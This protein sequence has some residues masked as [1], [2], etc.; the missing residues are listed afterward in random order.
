M[1][2]INDNWDFL[3]T[4]K[5]IYVSIL[6][7]THCLSIFCLNL[8]SLSFQGIKRNSLRRCSTW[9]IYPVIQS[10]NTPLECYHHKNDANH[11]FFK[12]SPD[13]RCSVNLASERHGARTIFVNLSFFHEYAVH[14]AIG[15]GIVLRESEVSYN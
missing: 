1:D 12:Y 7:T 5:Y 4:F 8:C 13:E 6:Q 2:F 10:V 14:N 15:M 3:D 9:W 11:S